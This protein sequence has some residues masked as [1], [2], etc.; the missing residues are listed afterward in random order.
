MK[1]KKWIVLFVVVLL[2]VFLVCGNGNSS[3]KEDDNVF[4][5]GV[6]GQSYLFVYKENGKLIGF[7][8]E[9]M[10]VVV[11]KIDMKLDWKLF[12]FSGLMGEF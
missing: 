3:S 5:V 7:D 10:E 1:K 2:V 12:E 4:Y 6:I 11:K 8:V 9:V